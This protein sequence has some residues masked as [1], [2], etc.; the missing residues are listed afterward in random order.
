MYRL[1]IAIMQPLMQYLLSNPKESYQVTV[2][3]HQSLQ[4]IVSNPTPEQSN[5][6]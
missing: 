3:F 5:N 2:E 6:L 1:C 4:P